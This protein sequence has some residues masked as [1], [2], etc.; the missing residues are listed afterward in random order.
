MNIFDA[1]SDITGASG[2]GTYGRLGYD[3]RERRLAEER[4]TDEHRAWVAA[5]RAG[6]VEP[7]AAPTW[8]RCFRCGDRV[9][10]RDTGNNMSP[11]EV[12]DH[13]TNNRHRW[14]CWKPRR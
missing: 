10:Y 2:S 4:E 12:Y 6:A 8:H 3:G 13:K 5:C 14:R 11:I 7:P 9:D 1:Y